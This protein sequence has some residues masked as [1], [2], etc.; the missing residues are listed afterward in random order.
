MNHQD[1]VLSRLRDAR[2][3]GDGWTAH[4]PVHDDG[5][6][7]LSVKIGRDGR[8]LLTCHAGCHLED[9]VQAIG[10]TTRDLFPPNAQS[11]GGRRITAT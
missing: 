6:E 5:K 4:C 7:S 3:S 8:V 1:L 10:L 11:N 9:I 2:R